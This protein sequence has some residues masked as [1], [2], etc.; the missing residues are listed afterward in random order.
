MMRVYEFLLFQRHA[1]RA[2]AAVH[3]VG[4]G[5]DVDAGLGLGQRLARQ[6]RD[7]LFVDDVAVVVRQAVLSMGRVRVEG[8][9][10]HDAQL[11]EVALQFAHGARD[12]AVRV[13][14]F[15]AV[16][17]LQRRFDDGEQREHGD[18]QRDGLFGHLQ[19]QVDRQALH[20]R[21]RRD[22]L[23]LVLAVEDEHGVDQ[24]GGGDD[25]FAHQGARE[26]VAP[27][28]AHAHGGVL[29]R[30]DDRHGGS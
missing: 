27:H 1:D 26:R 11:R 14:R 15:D 10:R 8:D 19:Q 17:G 22:L 20:A 3:H 21:H 7:R 2:D 13:R 25:I 18:T 4:R 28:A 12:E 30:C 5:D 6:H 24:V 16:I 23:A 29:R 9:V